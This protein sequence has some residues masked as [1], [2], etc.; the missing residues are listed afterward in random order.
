MQ[1]HRIKRD[2]I[3]DIIYTLAVK[4]TM[5]A[6]VTNVKVFAMAA[7]Y[8]IRALKDHARKKFTAIIAT[9]KEQNGSETATDIAFE[10][11][12]HCLLIH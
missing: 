1:L 12:A 5:G 7:K 9:P 3:R 2:G 4:Q 6:M 11:S 8:D 10:C